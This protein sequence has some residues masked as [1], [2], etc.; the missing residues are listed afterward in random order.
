[1]TMF[2][3]TTYSARRARLA[4]ELGSGLVLFLG[5]GETPMNYTDNA[6]A[7]RQDS[8]F[9]YYWGLAAPNLAAA[10]DADERREIVFGDEASLDDIV[11]MGP[12]RPVAQRARDV[13]AEETEPLAAL[14]DV[15]REAVQRGRRVHFLPQ[16]RTDNALWLERLLG[17]RP[18][19]QPHH[20]SL[21][22]IRTIVA[23]RSV[24]SEAEVAEIEHA[25]GI[26]RDMHMMAMRLTRPGVYEYEVAGSIEGV[27]LARGGRIAFPVIFSVHGETLHNHH[28]GNRMEAGQLA[29]NDSGAEGP[30]G[31]AGD[32]TRTIPVGGRFIGPQRD[33]YQAVLRAQMAAIDAVRPGVPYRDVHLLAARSL[34]GDLA[35]L[36]CMRGDLDAAVAA[37]AHALFFP[38]GLGHMMGLD[39]HD[40]ENLGENHVGYDE[41]IA[42]S[43]QFGLRSLRLARALEPGFVLTVEP[44]VYFIP[45]L[46]DRWKAERRLEEFVDYDGVEKFRHAGGIRIEDNVLVTDSGGRVLGPPIPKQM[47]EVEALATG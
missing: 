36:G 11:W 5:N 28:H 39:V 37:G 34:A 33:L 29:V 23:Q 9:L 12:Q 32:I 10:I 8:T 41:T 18:D 16:Y 38:H 21:P 26:T 43:T 27:A 19:M 4:A 3:A 1:M 24:K 7:F 40:M 47:A 15:V 25:V 13:G 22:L 30:L 42:R 14:G 6:Y 45:A 44:G 20:A 46:I 17:V 31:Y 35:A 2:D